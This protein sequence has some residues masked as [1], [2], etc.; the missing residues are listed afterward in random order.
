MSRTRPPIVAEGLDG[1]SATALGGS[2]LT[3]RRGGG[4]RAR[5]LRVDRKRGGRA[6][7]ECRIHW[8]L[9]AGRRPDSLKLEQSA[10]C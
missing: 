8:G 1:T 7:S 5:D 10:N 6:G 2:V 4:I 9:G 3:R